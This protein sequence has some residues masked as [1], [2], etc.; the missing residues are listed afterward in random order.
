MVRTFLRSLAKRRTLLETAAKYRFKEI[1]EIAAGESGAR[2]ATGIKFMTVLP[3]STKAIISL[4]FFSV[5]QYIVGF[6]DF[7][8]FFL[9]RGVFAD[10]GMI[11]SC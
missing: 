1:T 10:I 8:E 2:V 11:L 6:V 7:L 4:A 3:V 5:F 9:S